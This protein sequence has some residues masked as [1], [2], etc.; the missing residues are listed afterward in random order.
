MELFVWPSRDRKGYR[1]AKV[2]IRG[3]LGEY[4]ECFNYEFYF[5]EIPKEFGDMAGILGKM[6]P[7][8]QKKG[9]HVRV[10]ATPVRALVLEEK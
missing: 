6:Q 1:R 7:Q 5:L 3:Q 4:K 9:F 8:G 2:G 10:G